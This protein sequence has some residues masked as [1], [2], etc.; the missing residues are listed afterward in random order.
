MYTFVHT[1]IQ[2]LLMVWSIKNPAYYTK[3]TIFPDIIM[4]WNIIRTFAKIIGVIALN[5]PPQPPI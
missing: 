1:C 2:R 4:G 5:L 3:S